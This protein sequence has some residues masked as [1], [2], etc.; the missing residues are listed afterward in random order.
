[1]DHSRRNR[2]VGAQA[3]KAA[4]QDVRLDLSAVGRGRMSGAIQ[5]CVHVL[6]ARD[7]GLDLLEV[8]RWVD[9]LEGD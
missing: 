1:M 4:V 7:V 8:G 9:W 6:Q 3:A 2:V 5:A